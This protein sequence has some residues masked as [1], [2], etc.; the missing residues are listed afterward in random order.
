MKIDQVK[1][2]RFLKKEDIGDGL[3][4]TIKKVE[5]KNV[6]PADTEPDVKP[7]CHF[8]EADKPLVLNV[9]NFQTITDITGED[10]SDNW[11]G[12]QITL[13]FDSSIFFSGKKVGG[14]RVR[15][16]RPGKATASKPA[17]EP[18][19]HTDETDDN[20]DPVLFK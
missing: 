11:I 1:S 10:D 7:C 8:D 14:I 6:A 20:G 19:D 15:A 18:I 2:S 13:Y 16:P 12:K 9:T 5:M 17:V 4:V 3:L